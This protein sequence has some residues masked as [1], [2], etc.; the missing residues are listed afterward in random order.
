MK[1]KIKNKKTNSVGV[2]TVECDG[3]MSRIN[4]EFNMNDDM[5]RAIFKAGLV[6][7]YRNINGMQTIEIL[8]VTKM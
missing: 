3:A 5:F 6:N 8:D 7:M 1:F 2:I 4:H